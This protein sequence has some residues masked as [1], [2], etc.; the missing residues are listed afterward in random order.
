M[1]INS[2]VIA[3]TKYV[4]SLTASIML[5]GKTVPKV[6]GWYAINTLSGSAHESTVFNHIS[7]YPTGSMKNM[8]PKIT[9][10]VLVV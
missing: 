7:K 3:E 2:T 5:R 9:N 6:R 8:I 1:M 4:M 10:T